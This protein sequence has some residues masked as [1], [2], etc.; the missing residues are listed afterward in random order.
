M[1]DSQMTGGLPRS[2]RGTRRPWQTIVAHI[3][4]IE[5]QDLHDNGK[6]LVILVKNSARDD[7]EIYEFRWAK[8]C[9][10]KNTDESQNLPWN[11]E[12]NYDGAWQNTFTIE[13]SSWLF[14]LKEQN[15]LM[16]AIYPN[17]QH[18]VICTESFII[19]IIS[20]QEPEI[21]LL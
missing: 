14:S 1:N 7:S 20:D 2:P 12:D 10:Y 15:G 18:F 13:N 19:E 11:P 21:S 17:A 6:V 8:F 16:D 9:S 4:D 5:F 3:K